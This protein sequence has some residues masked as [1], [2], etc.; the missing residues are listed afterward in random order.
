MEWLASWQESHA[1]RGSMS[2][3]YGFIQ[4]LEKTT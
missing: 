1:R 4:A 2:K 3:L